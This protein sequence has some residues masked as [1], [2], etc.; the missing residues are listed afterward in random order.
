MKKWRIDA[1]KCKNGSISNCFDDQYDAIRYAIKVAQ[2]EPG[3][4]IFMLE[5]IFEDKYGNIIQLYK[6]KEVKN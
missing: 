5:N 2:R 4:D 6:G 3:A 1:F